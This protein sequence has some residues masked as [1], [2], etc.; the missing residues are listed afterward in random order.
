MAR[1]E[2][3]YLRGGEIIVARCE[4]AQGAPAAQLERAIA[5]AHGALAAEG[6]APEDVALTRL[7]MNDRE[8]AAEF[9]DVRDRLLRRVYR[10][11]S[12]SFF[13]R[14]RMG[15]G[16]V[17]SLEFY[18]VRVR[19]RATRRIVDFD[20]PRRY[21]HYLAVDDWLFLSGMAEEGET[22]DAQFDLAFAQVQAALDGQA[23]AWTDVCSASLFLQ[24][25]KGDSEWLLA[26]F[27]DAAP[28]APPLVTLEVVDELA[29]TP[30]HLEIE[31]IARRQARE[32]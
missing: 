6:L 11:A 26:R 29:N 5:E 8:S 15:A 23:C 18:A 31:V 27:R 16:G 14:E 13:S 20:P 7:W 9:N 17:V 25:G 1:V 12:S 10:S 21:A 2:R 22:M 19:D 28:V 30:K 24:R 32:T 3:L 4:G